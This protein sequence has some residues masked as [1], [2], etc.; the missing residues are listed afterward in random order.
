MRRAMS[1]SVC[2]S[3]MFLSDMFLSDMGASMRPGA[4]AFGA[5]TFRSPVVDPPTARQLRSPKVTDLVRPALRAP[6]NMRW[7]LDRECQLLS[8]R[9]QASGR[10]RARGRYRA[11]PPA[12]HR[13]P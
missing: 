8:R 10:R 7:T 6:T 13:G 12:L 3:D 11:L 5:T 1:G 9:A 4:Q 2:A